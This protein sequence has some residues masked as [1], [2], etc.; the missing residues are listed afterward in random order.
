M[1]AVEEQ[2]PPPAHVVAASPLATALARALDT[3]AEWIWLLDGR[4]IPQPGALGALLAAAA[5][6]PD[7]RLCL[8]S[9]QLVA[10][11]GTLLSA[12]APLPQADDA[13]VAADAFEKRT[14]ALRVVGYGSLMVRADVL[15]R[16]MPPSGGAGADLVWSARV[17][18]QGVGLLVPQSLAVREKGITARE[19][20]ALLA[21][22]ARLL[23]SDAVAAREK[24]WIALIYFDRGRALIA[25]WARGR[26]SSA[27]RPALPSR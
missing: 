21:G 24:P 2:S 1:R 11:D 8:L 20:V 19:R 12:E 26:R 18:A 23:L 3:S 4:A 10:G 6:W 16:A 15:R 22:W 17:L 5:A 14:C 13:D 9:S 7:E 27:S 25:E